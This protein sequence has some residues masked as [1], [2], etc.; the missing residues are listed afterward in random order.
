M[1]K[2]VAG[3]PGDQVEFNRSGSRVLVN[4]AQEPEEYVTLARPEYGDTKEEE[5]MSAI[6]TVMNGQYLVLGDNRA[7]SLDSRDRKIGTVP[8]EAILG[9]VVWIVRRGS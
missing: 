6:Q 8:S 2:R 7:E 1:V 9:R 4:G 5:R 3:L